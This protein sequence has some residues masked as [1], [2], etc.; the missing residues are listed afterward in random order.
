MKHDKIRKRHKIEQPSP[1]NGFS[2]TVAL[3][4]PT[5]EQKAIETSAFFDTKRQTSRMRK[6]QRKFARRCASIH[7]AHTEQ[8]RLN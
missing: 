2:Y 3:K 6:L 7:K 4:T 8:K 5:F 1:N